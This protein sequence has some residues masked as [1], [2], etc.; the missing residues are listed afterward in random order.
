MHG[1]PDATPAVLSSRFNVCGGS[2]Y[3]CSLPQGSQCFEPTNRGRTAFL[4]A[5]AAAVQTHYNINL[6]GGKTAL[7]RP[8]LFRKR[9][10]GP[11]QVCPLRR[12]G[13]G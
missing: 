8:C 10:R 9:K 2:L 1:G 6:H 5:L 4:A 7:C 11:S 13:K 3:T 12:S